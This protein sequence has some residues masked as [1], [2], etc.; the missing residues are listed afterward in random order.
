MK[1]GVYQ[2]LVGC[3]AAIGSFLFGYD[4]GVIAEVVASDSFKSLFLQSNG[5]TRSGTVVAL[6]TGGCFCGAF[7]ASYTDRLGRR[8]TILM[9]C[10]IFVVGGIIQ[11]AGV[12]IAMLYVGRLIAGLGVGFLTMIIPIYQAELSHRKIRGKITSL[13][14]LFN[15]IGQIFATWI[16]WLCDHDRAEEGLKTLAK[17]HAHGDISDPY[18]IAEYELIQAQIAEEHSQRKVGYIDLFKGW[19]NLRRTILVMAI[20]ASCQMTG[21]SAIQYFSP[22][23]FAQIG[24]STGESLLF[25][26]VTAIFAFLGTATC[27]AT[28]DSVGRRPLEIYGCLF[29]CITFVINAAI[30]KVFPASAPSTGAHWAF[31]VLTWLFNF[32]FF[33]TSGP[34]SWSIP[35]ELFGTAM[36]LKGVSWGAMTSF[37]FNT[38]IGQVTPIAVS[39]IGWQYYIVF[40][41][42]NLGNAIFFWAFL[43]ETKGLN[44]EDMDELFRDHPTFVPRSHWVPSSHIDE[45]ALVY[46]KR[47]R[48]LESGKTAA[49][50]LQHVE[51][52]A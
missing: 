43:P 46:S 31:V 10:C 25:Q 36:R 27:I 33:W 15:A 12:V 37:A 6:F 18:V 20:Q 13:Q 5:D 38:M 34:L 1:S 29:L 23:I 51:R 49:D 21:V 28:I 41:V 9:A 2:F 44:L 22:Q 30:I 45:D 8:G 24:I 11:T 17:L 47:E 26:G 42:C 7:L 48:V 4:L 39:A 52:A 32:V 40:I 35:A 16:G 19:P 14:Q 50:V 3:F